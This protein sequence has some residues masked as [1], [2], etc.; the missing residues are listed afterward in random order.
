[1]IAPSKKHLS[2]FI[3]LLSVKQQLKPLMKC[4]LVLYLSVV[5]RTGRGGDSGRLE[6]T[7]SMKWD[8]RC[9]RSS[10]LAPCG[11]VDLILWFFKISCK[12]GLSFKSSQFLNASD[13]FLKFWE[14]TNQYYMECMVV[15]SEQ[16]F[17]EV[18]A[19]E[20]QDQRFRLGRTGLQ[21][22]RRRC[23]LWGFGNNPGPVDQG[24]NGIHGGWVKTRSQKHDTEQVDYDTP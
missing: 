6:S 8:Q 7:C 16:P 9:L 19:G 13:W 17:E 23:A 21:R 15:Y 22:M 18:L 3:A 20:P 11:M 10:P 14:C 2:F 4:Q 1:M 5:D 12:S 24:L